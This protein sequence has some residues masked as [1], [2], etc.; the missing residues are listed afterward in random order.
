[1]VCL[2]IVLRPMFINALSGRIH[3]LLDLMKAKLIC[4][5]LLMGFH[6]YRS[7]STYDFV[8]IFTNL[9]AHPGLQPGQMATSWS[10]S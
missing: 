9:P 6:I 3:F 8:H 5:Y 7:P 2:Y 1:M 10:S 4:L